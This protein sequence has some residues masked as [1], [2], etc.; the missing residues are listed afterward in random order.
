MRKHLN[1]IQ[2]S[3]AIVPLFVILFHAK[4]FLV[5]YFHYNF[6][7]LPSVIK[8]G[9]V[10]YFFALSGF[11]VYYLH[12]KDFGNINKFSSF[13]YNR[14]IRIYPLYWILTVAL[15]TIYLV[16]PSLNNHSD[17]SFLNMIRSFL[18][19]PNPSEPILGVAWSLVYTVLFYLVF[20]LLFI[21]NKVISVLLPI[22]WIVMSILFT[23][24]ILS[25]DHYII[26]YFFNSYNLIFVAGVLCGVIIKKV[27][28]SIFVSVCMIVVGFIGFPFSWVNTQYQFVNLNFELSITISSILL[29]LGFASTDLQKD[30]KLPKIAKFLGEASFSIYLTHYYCMGAIAVFLGYF[31]FIHLPNPIIAVLLIVMSTLSGCLVYLLL[32]KPINWKL[33]KLWKDKRK[34][35][36]SLDKCKLDADQIV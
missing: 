5:F 9:G 35:F 24:N 8:S 6:L 26:H 22:V 7:N 32:E 30:V 4:G 23:I 31:S 1:L 15:L 13:L 11:M 14:F 16:F 27:K 28:I 3:R 25:S 34:H 29:I 10:Y 17:V 20:S 33:K 12:E 21:K 19:L 36:S 2:F 18:L